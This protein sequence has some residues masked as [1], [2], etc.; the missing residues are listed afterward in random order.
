MTELRK[1]VDQVVKAMVDK[2]GKYL[3]SHWPRKSTGSVS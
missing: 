2:E 3:T 1:T